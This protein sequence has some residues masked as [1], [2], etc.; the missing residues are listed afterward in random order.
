MALPFIPIVAAVTPLV[1]G[2]FELFRGRSAVKEARM[3][4]QEDRDHV[5]SLAALEERLRA[6]EDSDLEQARLVS[7]LAANLERAARASDTT[8]GASE[9]RM[10]RHERLVWIALTAAFLALSLSTWSLVH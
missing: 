3:A 5:R 9:A 7:E 6:L 10:N 4:R 8:A 2:A 1:L